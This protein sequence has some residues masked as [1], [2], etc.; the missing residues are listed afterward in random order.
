MKKYVRFAYEFLLER[1]A[2]IFCSYV[3]LKLHASS[4]TMGGDDYSLFEVND[5]P[6]PASET[7]EFSM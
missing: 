3:M 5:A 6:V 7:F 1:K 2:E 4:A